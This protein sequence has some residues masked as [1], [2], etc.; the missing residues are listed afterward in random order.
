MLKCLIPPHV[1]IKYNT[2][3]AV[4]GHF[5]LWYNCKTADTPFWITSI[6]HIHDVTGMQIGQ[7]IFTVIMINRFRYI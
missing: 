5:L 3:Q 6:N 2:F 7:D 4:Y 1:L